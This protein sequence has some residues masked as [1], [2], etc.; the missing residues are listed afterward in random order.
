MLGM[1]R[2]GKSTLAERLIEHWREEYPTSHTVIIDSKPRFMATHELNGLTTKFTGRYKNWD[3]G[4]EIPDSV[5]LPMR[6]IDA[7]LRH[8]WNFK[9]HVVI[10]QIK[11]RSEILKL[12]AV[13]QSAYDH[14]KKNIPLFF[15]VDELNNFFRSSRKAI[16][17]ITMVITSGGERSVAFLGAA[18]RPRWI[19]VEAMESM[20]KLYWFK[21]PFAEDVKHLR[22]M[23]VPLNTR[24]PENKYDFYFFDRLSNVRGTTKIALHEK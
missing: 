8:A 16:E 18:Q 11:R 19:G 15:Y 14:R 13:I 23:G 12:D 10:A 2:V 1:T 24:P 4:A 6:N 5:V 22:S 3:Y 20:T 17:G 7:E 9:Y 21:T